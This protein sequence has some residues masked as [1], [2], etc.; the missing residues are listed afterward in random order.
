MS[1][2]IFHSIDN[3]DVEIAGAERANFAAAVREIFDMSLGYF[4]ADKKGHF[5][6]Q[7]FL[8]E[9]HYLKNSDNINDI[10]SFKE[11]L[12][13]SIHYS[14]S[15]CHFI[16]NNEQ[17]NTFLLALNTAIVAGSDVVKFMTRIHAQCEIHCYVEGPNRKWLSDIIE[18]GYKSNILR[19]NMRRSGGEG[20]Q[21][22]IDL[23][24]KRDD[25]PIV[26]SYSV[27]ESFPNLTTSNM[28]N[29]GINENMTE[30]EIDQKRY[31]LQ[32]KYEN[33]PYEERFNIGMDYLRSKQDYGLELKPE[34]WN[35]YY[36]GEKLTGFDLPILHKKYYPPEE[37]PIS[38][39]GVFKSN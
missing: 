23:L 2:I 34:N 20:W 25:S 16:I 24:R 35:D 10:Y 9:N 6:I 37:A 30:Q 7:D 15:D 26:C 18:K 38:S 4:F 39:N 5:W 11:M 22:V 27:C 12:C 1:A 13:R 31:E 36:F 8:P 19:P 29:L 28:N 33:L 3:D 21:D 32:E 17:Y 14:F